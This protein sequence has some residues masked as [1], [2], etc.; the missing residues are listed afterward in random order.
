MKTQKKNTQK[1]STK[2]TSKT[3]TRLQLFG[4]AVTAV[5]RQLG[6]LGWKASDAV[7][8][9]QKLVP[10]ANPMTLRALVY[11]GARKQDLD[12]QAKLTTAQVLVLKK[13]VA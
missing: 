10:K 5:A 13:S 4:F 1:K 12:R 7:K 11:R 2:K 6:R 9:I 8:A 3:A